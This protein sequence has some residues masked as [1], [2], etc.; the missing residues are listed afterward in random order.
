MPGRTV[1]KAEVAI[2]ESAGIKLAEAI[3]AP[4]HLS[5][6]DLEVRSPLRRLVIRSTGRNVNAICAC[7]EVVNCRCR[8]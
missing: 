7:R 2:E 1:I 5:T 8:P 3:G 6:D 4:A